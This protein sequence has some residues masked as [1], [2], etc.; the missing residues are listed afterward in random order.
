MLL[1]QRDIEIM[2][3]VHRF[4]FCTGRHI[5]ELAAFSSSRVCDK[6]LRVLVTAG[7]LNRKKYLYGL[8]YLYTLSHKGRMLIGANK[9]DNKIRLEQITHDISVL[10]TLLH[11]KNKYNLSLEEVQSEKELHIKDGF[12][13]RKH[14][15]DFVFTV[16]EKTH[17][18]EVELTPKAKANMER[19]VRDNYL[20]YDTQIW[21]TN[22]NKILA[23][24]R[25][26]S[27]EYPN[28]EII[29]L[30]DIACLK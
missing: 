16:D 28:I 17:A 27:N 19:N 21:L 8:P 20:N 4:K 12:A 22:D 29:R 9:R 3:L 10:D 14:H 1:V 30:E 24:L 13:A 15:P 7:Y 11:F 5:K 18:V 2:Q 25:G 23:F 26:F 6:R